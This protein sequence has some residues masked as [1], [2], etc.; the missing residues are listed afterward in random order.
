MTKPPFPSTDTGPSYSPDGDRILFESNRAYP[1]GC[2]ASLFIVDADGTG[3]A[4]VPLPWDAYE[5]SWGTAPS[6]PVALQRSGCV[7]SVDGGMI[8]GDR[9]DEVR[10]SGTPE[11]G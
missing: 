7:E 6:I 4:A 2:C 3:L 11:R 5:P 9:T 8:G 10:A 1:D